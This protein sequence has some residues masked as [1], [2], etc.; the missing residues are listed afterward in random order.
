M[1]LAQQIDVKVALGALDEATSLGVEAASNN[2]LDSDARDAML[3]LTAELRHRCM[4]LAIRKMDGGSEYMTL[5][6]LL[7][8]A[9]RVTG[10]DIYG[11]QTD[12]CVE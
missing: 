12:S 6:R 7:R 2:L 4:L 1:K 9:N 8:Q 3:R 11:K 5:E 10:Q